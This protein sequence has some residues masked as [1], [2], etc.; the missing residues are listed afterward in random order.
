MLVEKKIAKKWLEPTNAER[1][2]PAS[3]LTAEVQLVEQNGPVAG[4]EKT[5]TDTLVQTTT[6]QKRKVPPILILLKSRRMLTAAWGTLTCS[7]VMTALDTTIPIYVHRLWGWDSLGAGLVFLALVVPNFAGP[8][9]GHWADKYGPKWLAAAGLI[10]SIP[11]LVLLRLVDHGG[12]S[13]KVTF[14]ALLALL[15]GAQ[16]LLMT[17]LMAEFSKVC[18]A[19]VKKQPDV[20]AGKSAYAQSYGIFNIAWAAGSMIGPL[21]AG[22]IVSSAGWK[23]MTWAISLFCVVGII[24]VV[25]FSGGSTGRSKRSNTDEGQGGISAA[26]IR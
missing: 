2:N 20:F 9:I 12:I 16:A 25:L 26:E 1:I 3:T 6:T 5:P 15:G 10:L 21:V 8:V 18:V 17:S 23:T 13:Q 24:P 19:K 14:C 22:S 7:M 11:F 4:V